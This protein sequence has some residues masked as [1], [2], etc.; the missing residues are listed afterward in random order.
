[1]AIVLH[2]AAPRRTYHFS[3][4]LSYQAMVTR[5]CAEIRNIDLQLRQIHYRPGRRLHTLREIDGMIEEFPQKV[6]FLRAYFANDRVH[7]FP[8]S[9]RLMGCR[10]TVFNFSSLHR[11]TSLR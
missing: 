10:M 2:N 1:M 7:L 5:L 4:N 11:R 8:H 3:L 6:M 9:A